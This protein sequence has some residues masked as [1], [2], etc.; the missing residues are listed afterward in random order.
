VHHHA[1]YRQ[2]KI[3][4]PEILRVLITHGFKRALGGIL[5]FAQRQPAGLVL[6]VVVLQDTM[7]HFDQVTDLEL[8]LG[9]QIVSC[10]QDIDDAEHGQAEHKQH[11]HPPNPVAN[12]Q[13]IRHSSPLISFDHITF[14]RKKA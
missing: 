7:G 13:A 1:R 9:Q 8:F 10:R 4:D 14:D 2:G 6:V 12:A 3:V 11:H 5:R